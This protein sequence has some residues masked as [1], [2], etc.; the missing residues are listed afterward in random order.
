MT[1]FDDALRR[2]LAGASF[3]PDASLTLPSG[4]VLDADEANAFASGDTPRVVKAASERLDRPREIEG[5]AS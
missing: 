3:G 5:G 4:E 1:A 2:A